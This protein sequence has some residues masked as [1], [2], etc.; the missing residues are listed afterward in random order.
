M[1]TSLPKPL[2]SIAHYL[3][4][5]KARNGQWEE[6]VESR[7]INSKPVFHWVVYGSFSVTPSQI[8]G[9]YMKLLDLHDSDFPVSDIMEL[10]YPLDPQLLPLE[11]V[12]PSQ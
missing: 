4:V 11:P 8:Y 3:V 7:T 1:I 12:A 6:I 10:K 5:M 9:P 2:E